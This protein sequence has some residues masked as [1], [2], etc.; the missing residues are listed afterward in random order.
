MDLGSPRARLRHVL[1][2]GLARAVA[3]AVVVVQVDGYIVETSLL[4]Q[5]PVPPRAN[6]G[7]RWRVVERVEGGGEGGGGEGRIM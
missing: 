7:M 5:L 1:A 6:W 2:D 4:G 3:V